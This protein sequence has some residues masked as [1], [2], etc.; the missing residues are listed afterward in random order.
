V[1]DAGAMVRFDSATHSMQCHGCFSRY[2]VPYSVIRNPEKFVE[3][4]D[5]IEQKHTVCRAFIYHE[6]RTKE[7]PDIFWKKEMARATIN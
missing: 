3:F 5:T 7:Q 1:V 4:Q 6:V 2:E